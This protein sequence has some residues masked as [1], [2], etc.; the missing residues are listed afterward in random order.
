M[1][2]VT[3]LGPLAESVHALLLFSINLIVQLISNIFI[4]NKFKMSPLKVTVYWDLF[5]FKK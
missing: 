3:F 5:L 1:I 4:V 2:K